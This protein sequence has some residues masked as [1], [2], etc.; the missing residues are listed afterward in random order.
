MEII[1][2]WVQLPQA[3]ERVPAPLDAVAQPP[4]VDKA[5]NMVDRCVANLLYHRYADTP[6]QGNGDMYGDGGQ[7]QTGSDSGTVVGP[8]KLGTSGMNVIRGRHGSA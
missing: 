2:V 4:V 3:L 7:Q 1:R 5:Q 8:G 6:S